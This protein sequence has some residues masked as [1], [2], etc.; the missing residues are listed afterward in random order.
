[1]KRSVLVCLG[2][3]VWLAACDGTPSVPTGPTGTAGSNP[4][5]PPVTMY[6]VSGVVRTSSG[7]PVSGARVVVLGQ[8]GSI[9]AATDGNGNYSI[10]GVQ[11]SF[12]R[13]SPLL[14]ASSASYFTDVEFADSNYLPIVK[15]TK[16]DFSLAPV[17]PIS[18]G[19]VI[20]G[21][22]PAGDRVCSHWGYGSSACQRF[23]LTAPTSGT[24]EV[25]VSAS[26]FEFDFDVVGPDGTF[27]LYDGSWKSPLRVAIPVNGGSTYEIR[28]IG[29][30]SPPREFEL[31]TA[32]R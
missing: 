32:L 7:V 22:S 24:L 29:G 25:T 5:V 10:S 12:D 20:Q 13:M 21:R 17:A 15:D 16:L 14:S 27:A 6:T 23:A 31:R 2:G 9:S 26:A 8:A 1:M 19:E 18:L 3:I 11:A 28:V 30:W 4:P